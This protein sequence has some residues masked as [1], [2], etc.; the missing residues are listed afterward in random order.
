MT[1]NPACC[2]ADSPLQEAA[3]L[4][5][6]HD[7]G[8]IPVL[9]FADRPI[10]VITDRDI[11]CRAIAL[12]KNPLDLTVGDCMTSPCVTVPEDMSLSDCCDVLEQNQIRRVPV[13]DESGRCCGI[14]SQADVAL[15]STKRTAAELV[16]A[17]SQPKHAGPVAQ[18]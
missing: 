16:R 10:G 4:M 14:V 5:V 11:V 12:G 6:E 17:V 8:E 18:A 15:A 3:R 9:D 2:A 1:R 7:C 13:I